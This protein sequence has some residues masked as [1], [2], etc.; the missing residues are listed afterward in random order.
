MDDK[1]ATTMDEQKEMSMDEQKEMSMNEKKEIVA[2]YE[3]AVTQKG[4]DLADIC[5]DDCTFTI[6]MNS[7]MPMN[8]TEYASLLKKLTGAF[9]DYAIKTTVIEEAD[10]SLAVA[11]QNRMGKMKN[12]LCP[13]ENRRPLVVA[14]DLPDTAKD[15]DCIMPFAVVHF[16]FSSSGLISKVEWRGE[17]GDTADATTMELVPPLGEQCL[18]KWMGVEL[19][20]DLKDTPRCERHEQYDVSLINH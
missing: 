6:P 12:D 11:V 5:T 3:K 18:Y 17:V 19:K 1:K 8:C 15:S 7:S 14:A 13:L 4:D 20:D 16:S 10:G 2:R 9:P